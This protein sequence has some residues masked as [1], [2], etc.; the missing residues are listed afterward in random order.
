MLRRTFIVA[1]A[2]VLLSCH[3]GD[4]ARKPVRA[5]HNRTPRVIRA[6]SGAEHLVFELGR[7]K[8]HSRVE[9]RYS[10]PGGTPSLSIAEVRSPCGCVAARLTLPGGLRMPIPTRVP[11]DLGPGTVLEG[12]LTIVEDGPIRQR[13]EFRAPS[14]ACAVT[15]EFVAFGFTPLRAE[16]SAAYL[17]ESKPRSTVTATLHLLREDR[18]AVEILEHEFAGHGQRPR[19]V[20]TNRQ[21]DGSL[22]V[23]CAFDVG[24][25]PGPESTRVTFRDRCGDSTT[26]EIIT[27]VSSPVHLP[28]GDMISLGSFPA[29][30]GASGRIPISIEGDAHVRVACTT[31]LFGAAEARCRVLPAAAGREFTAELTVTSAARGPVQG[32]IKLE[33][34]GPARMSQRLRFVG[35]AE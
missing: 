12:W 18:T 5:P 34:E 29:A 17:G 3:D 15:A 4:Q 6:T 28:Q 31:L 7:H 9:Y 2:T 19:L 21:A 22:T 14:G 30:H 10:F 16:P 32:L 24:E 25:T 8:A 1:A 35:K 27:T 13:I 11:F 20:S 33:I 26:A 23:C